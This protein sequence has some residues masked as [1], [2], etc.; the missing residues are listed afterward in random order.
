MMEYQ[1]KYLKYKL[2]Y[3]KLKSHNK[4]LTGGSKKQENTLYLFKA[5]WCHHC[6]DFKSTWENLQNTKGDNINFKTYDADKDAKI[7]KQYKIDGYP[8]LILKSGNGAYEYVG[9][10]DMNSI[11]NFIDK[12][13]E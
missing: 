8:T 6:K 7:I 9:P 12:Y 13:N 2:K 3:I 1:E 10:R 4:Q 11:T 5:E